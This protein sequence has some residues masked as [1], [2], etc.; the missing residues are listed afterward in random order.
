MTNSRM[1]ESFGAFWRGA[2]ADSPPLGYLL[3]RRYRE[4]WVRFHSLPGS[5]RYATT[6][7]ERET[8]LGRMNTLASDVLGDDKPCWLVASKFVD[9]NAQWPVEKVLGGRRLLPAFRFIDGDFGQDESF[10]LR[11]W[12]CRL[13]WRSGAVDDLLAGVADDALRGILA[14]SCATAA[15]FAPYDG[16]ADLILPDPGQALCVKERHA[17]WLSGQPE[18]L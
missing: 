12:V 14:V 8:V 11:S 13:C 6:K 1:H 9:R 16:G 5:K 15:V 17:G 18:G 7:G 4:R 3:R 2:Y 10:E